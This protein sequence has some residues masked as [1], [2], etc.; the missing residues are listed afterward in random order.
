MKKYS[1]S[2]LVFCCAASTSSYEWNIRF[3]SFSF[4]FLKYALALMCVLHIPG[5]CNYFNFP[6][7]ILLSE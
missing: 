3:L 5:D 1:H 7:N 6:L 4:L 2:E